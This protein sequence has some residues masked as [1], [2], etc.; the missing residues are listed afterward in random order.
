MRGKKHYI[1][2]KNNLEPRTEGLIAF[3]EQGEEGLDEFL[4]EQWKRRKPPETKEKVETS[5]D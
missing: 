3:Q 2:D 4:T 5:K 1:D